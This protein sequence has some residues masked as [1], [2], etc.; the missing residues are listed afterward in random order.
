V[1]TD[2]EAEEIERRRKGGVSGGPIVLSW[3]DQLLADRKERVRQ[4]QYL[5]QRLNQAFRYLDGLVRDV[6]TSRPGPVSKAKA[7]CCPSCGKAY[8]RAYGIS[9]DGIAYVHADGREC[10]SA[11]PG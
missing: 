3:V 8:A 1:L 6:Q 10:R 4:L 11:T 2:R 7:L 9:P 5:R